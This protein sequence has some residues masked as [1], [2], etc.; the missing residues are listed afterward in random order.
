MPA[1]RPTRPSPGIAL[2]MPRMADEDEP[3][4]RAFDQVS[5]TVRQ[6]QARVGA[7]SQVA[8]AAASG[9]ATATWINVRDFGAVGNGATDDTVSVQKAIADSPGR[10]LYFP[11]GKYPLASSILITNR[12][13]HLVGDFGNRDSDNGTEFVYTGTG[14]AIQIGVDNGLAWN[15][16]LYNG[17]QD[18]L[19]ENIHISHGAP[20]TA[21]V[22]VGDASLRYK[23]GAY[24]IW[25]WRGGGITTRNVGL[26]GFEANFVAIESDFDDLEFTVSLYSKYG[27]YIGPR[28]DQCTI[29]LRDSFFCDRSITIDGARMVRILNSAFVGCGHS[30]ASPIE[31][32]RGSSH[33]EVTNAWFE[34]LSPVGYAG[35]DAQSCVSVGEVD[36][37]GAGGSIVSPGGTPN[38]AS[39]VAVEIS[40]PLVYVQA[41]ATPYHV[42]SIAT[43][44]KCHGFVLLHPEAPPGISLSNLDALVLIQ[45]AQAP[46]SAE[47]QI[48]IDEINS[49]MTLAQA[50][51]N[52]GAGSPAVEI[53][54]S[55]ASGMKLYST[56]RHSLLAI[57]AAAGADEIQ[58]SQQGSV[59]GI[60]FATPQFTGG[61]TTRLRISRSVQWLS[62]AGVAPSTGTWQK[63]DIV[64]DTDASAGGFVGFY[65]TASGTPGTW[66]TFGAIS[67]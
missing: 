4:S 5:L 1:F 49:S 52:L 3:T 41:I 30:T 12:S 14:P 8:N 38:T 58:I 57:G 54:A 60:F 44:G 27:I 37:Y 34:H 32:R 40:N 36:G 45:A 16:G 7:V 22:S 48:L 35:T 18:H 61:Q 47:T 20:D 26:E 10:T 28:S 67:P 62:Q 39:A 11:K 63:G 19:F 15:L 51:T 6:L 17:P 66:K 59:G 55:G 13:T 53:R 9:G 65:C 31:V 21:L 64:F 42:K 43:V 24:G 29:N 33:V 25:D 50:Y 56:S 2:S 46:N 23:A